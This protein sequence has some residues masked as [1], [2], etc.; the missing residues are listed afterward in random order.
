MQQKDLTIMAFDVVFCSIAYIVLLAGIL[1]V[2]EKGH[3]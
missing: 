3:L 2:H 1:S